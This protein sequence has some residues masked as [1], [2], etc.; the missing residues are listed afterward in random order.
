MRFNEE[1]QKYQYL[2]GPKM[3]VIDIIA[4]CEI[5]QVLAM[6]QRKI[7]QQLTK[8]VEWYENIGEIEAI[9]EMNA[10]LVEVLDQHN[11]KEV[12]N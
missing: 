2:T 6:Y 11:L 7:P 4:Y 9:K 8:L 1:L 5:N 3:T 10:K 12:G